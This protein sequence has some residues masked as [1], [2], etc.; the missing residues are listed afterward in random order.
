MR[1]LLATSLAFFILIPAAAQA[2]R[3]QIVAFG[4]YT[5]EAQSSERDEQGIMKNLSTNFR[6]A[7]ATTSVPAQLGVRFGI[8]FKISG[9]SNNQTITLRKV[10]VYP[11]PGL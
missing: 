11:P 3:I 1:N 10:V 6:L 5:A 9:L 7:V 8:Q 2:Q 4:I